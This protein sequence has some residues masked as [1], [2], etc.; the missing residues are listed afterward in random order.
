[1]CS[2]SL[3]DDPPRPGWQP[4][5]MLLAAVEGKNA[6]GFN[7][8]EDRLPPYQLPDPLVRVAGTS[9]TR[10]AEWT[11]KRRPETLELFQRYVYGRPPA[12][13]FEMKFAV[14]STDPGVLGGTATLKRVKITSAS[15]G[16]SFTFEAA[17]ITP[18]NATRKLPAFMLI[19]HRGWTNND[20]VQP[21]P[22]GYWSVDKIVARGYA[23]VTFRAGDV[24]ADR[25]GD[26]ARQGGVRAVWPK[27]GTAGGDDWGTIAA[28]AWG[29][30]RVLDYLETDPAIDA[31]KVAV[32]GQS[33]GGKASLWAGAQDERFALVIPNNSGCTGAALSRRI[34]GE[35]VERI[36]TSF[37]HWFC[38]NYKKYNGKE[39]E[40]PVD[41]HQAIALVAPR[42]VYVA[43]SDGDFWAD[44]RGEFLSLANASPV[45][46]LFG[47]PGMKPSEMPPLDAPLIRG[48][49]AYHIRT[50][51][52]NLLTSDWIHFMDYADRL[53]AK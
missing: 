27:T 51:Q 14:T 38:E 17:V 31:K 23:A 48:P 20:P 13:P 3:A 2:A 7:Y 43:S 4:N 15:G 37:P 39:N 26:E 52:H 32:V 6:G 11:Q 33:R 34:F 41:Q 1:M 8:R 29:A 45:F 36:N 28:W 47:A 24:D 9:L 16:K 22:V 49:M 42:A 40:L 35:T 10:A 5:P 19:S 53:W 25:A 18:N 44:Q 50:G 46:A 30:S 21:D 12:G